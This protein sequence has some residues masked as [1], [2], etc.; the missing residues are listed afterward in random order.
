MTPL[1]WGSIGEHKAKNLWIRFPPFYVGSKV[2]R[3]AAQADE[4][5]R[6]DEARDSRVGTS[7][8]AAQSCDGA[9]ARSE[10]A[11]SAGADAWGSHRP[12][13]Q[14]AVRIR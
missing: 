5:R 7:E 6:G 10:A 12:I 9:L 4:V 13:L 1:A 14:D 11:E 3:E 8:E 2:G